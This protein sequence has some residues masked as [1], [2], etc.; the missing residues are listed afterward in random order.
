MPR[1]FATA[2]SSTMVRLLPT[3]AVR[4]RTAESPRVP[5]PLLQAAACHCVST[6]AG[7]RPGEALDVDHLKD[8]SRRD[9][10][11][12]LAWKRRVRPQVRGQ[13]C[14][15][16]EEGAAGSIV[17]DEGVEGAHVRSGACEAPKHNCLVQ[18]CPVDVLQ[19]KRN[20]SPENSAS[21]WP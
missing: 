18:L 13:A 17:R 20:P 21:R 9:E 15:H 16:G 1:R 4:I 7:G 2:L 3:K 19:V 10:E 5:E 12:P 14:R 8:S 11:L 6:R